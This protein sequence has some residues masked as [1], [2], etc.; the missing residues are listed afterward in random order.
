MTGPLPCVFG[1]ARVADRGDRRRPAA[2]PSSSVASGIVVTAA[3]TAV[4]DDRLAAP[5][6]Q[7]VGAQVV[8]RLVPVVRAPSRGT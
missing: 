3:V 4:P 7:E 5:E 1:G 2:P 6:A 8:G